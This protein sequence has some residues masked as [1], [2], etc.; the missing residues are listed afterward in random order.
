MPACD[1]DCSVW[2]HW[3]PCVAE[4]DESR[5]PQEWET[6]G[7]QFV[8]D[9]LTGI[10]TSIADAKKLV[11]GVIVRIENMLFAKKISKWNNIQEMPNSKRVF[12]PIFDGT[13]F[14]Y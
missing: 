8:E 6:N 7:K 5:C 13:I 9:S 14:E 1:E 11:E 4:C 3:D 10:W 12:I 2:D